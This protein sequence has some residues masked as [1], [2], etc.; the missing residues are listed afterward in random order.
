MF[1]RN[2]FLLFLVLT[3]CSQVFAQNFGTGEVPSVVARANTGVASISP[4]SGI[5]NPA[6]LANADTVILVGINT[7]YNPSWQGWNQQNIMAFLPFGNKGAGISASHFGDM[8]YQENSAGAAIGSKIRQFALGA[9]IRY[10]QVSIQDYGSSGNAYFDFGGQVHVTHKLIIGAHIFNFTQAKIK[11][12]WANA[13]PVMMKAG[14]SYRV[15]KEIMAYYE[16]NKSV[17]AAETHR[18]GLSYQ[19]GSI[20]TV[21]GGIALH[22]IQYSAGLALKLR[23]LGV[24]V[25]FRQEKTLGYQMAFGLHYRFSHFSH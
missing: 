8:L 5:Y 4:W 25:A 13:M 1:W 20:V 17:I 10:W 14:F 3:I 6:G 15:S 12:E 21:Q 24:D 22:P 9:G 18:V 7:V 16:M 23:T 2:N 11:G 19:L